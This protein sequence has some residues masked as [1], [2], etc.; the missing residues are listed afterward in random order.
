MLSETLLTVLHLSIWNGLASGS[1][2]RDSDTPGLRAFFSGTF[3]GEAM[4]FMPEEGDFYH[5]TGNCFHITINPSS[6]SG[7]NLLTALYPTTGAI[8]GDGRKFRYPTPV[9]FS[10]F[11]DICLSRN[12]LTTT[13]A[14]AR[15]Y[16]P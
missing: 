7:A 8:G 11:C 12:K 9:P 6:P 5:F 16:H 10:L 3:L 15:G 4:N 13:G 1:V 2:G 14:E